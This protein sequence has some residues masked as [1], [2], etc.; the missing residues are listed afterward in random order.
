ML[1]RRLV[2]VSRCKAWL[3]R[4]YLFI[5]LAGT[6]AGA[7]A[8]P[9]SCPPGTLAGFWPPGNTIADCIKI[10]C[11]LPRAGSRFRHSHALTLGYF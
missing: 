8:A 6:G 1:T 5:Y 3:A 10:R 2:S 4:A 7:T 9:H 11:D